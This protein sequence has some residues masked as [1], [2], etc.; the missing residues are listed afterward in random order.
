MLDKGDQ[1]WYER[2]A[3]F[4]L[5]TITS[6]YLASIFWRDSIPAFITNQWVLYTGLGLVVL[7]ILLK[8]L[9]KLHVLYV[10]D[11]FLL[12]CLFIW[13]VYW[14]KEYT[15][16]APVFLFFSV[17]FVP[18]NLLFAKF[19][20]DEVFAED[21]YQLLDFLNQRV[22]FQPVLLAILVLVGLY[23]QSWYLLFP[24]FT[25]LLMIRVLLMLW[26]EKIDNTSTLPP[27]QG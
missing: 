27:A 4:P 6:A 3:L 10:C 2:I 7:S 16:E 21:Q 17:Y 13:V 20:R 15:F 8:Q 26:T 1:S 18:L 23:L 19:A 14:Q 5:F 9:F 24:L 11:L 12:G 25:S 22:L